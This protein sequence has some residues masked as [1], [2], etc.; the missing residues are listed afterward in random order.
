[1]VS[2]LN[3]GCNNIESVLRVRDSFVTQFKN[4]LFLNFR[5]KMSRLSV[6]GLD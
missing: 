4:Y 6:C 2:I 1:M 3:Q 5:L